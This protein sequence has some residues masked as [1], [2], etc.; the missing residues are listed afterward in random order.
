MCLVLEMMSTLAVFSLIVGIFGV[1]GVHPN[2]RMK[3]NHAAFSRRCEVCNLEF[4]VEA[5]YEEHMQSKRHAANLK[6]WKEPSDVYIE[7]KSTCPGWAEGTS[8]QDVARLWDR[9]NELSSPELALKFRHTTLSPS[10]KVS[11][12]SPY[13]KARLWRYLRSAIGPGLSTHFKE[14]AQILYYVDTH[15]KATSSLRVKEIFES[16]EAF[17]L[18]ENFIVATQRTRRSIGQPP[19]NRI[20]EVAA[21]HGLVGMLLAYRF[22][23]IHVSLY[24][25][26]KRDSYDLYLEAF[27]RG[28]GHKSRPENACVLPNLDFH[29][30]DMLQAREEI[31]GNT[32]VFSVHGCNE[33]NED[34]ILLARDAEAPWAV[35]P[36]CI[37]QGMYVGS[38]AAINLREDERDLRHSIM[39]GALSHAYEAQLIQEIDRRITNRSIFIGGGVTFSQAKASV[40]EKSSDYEPGEL[41]RA[42]SKGGIPRLLM[43]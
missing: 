20:V 37:R 9:E 5:G 22:S 35:I 40:P 31:T 1:H 3:K 6:Y 15:P 39:C 33:V 43:S 21:G 13:Q 4:R 19:V 34:T 8:V 27:E 38:T 2:T 11:D 28:G 16:I 42:A 36:C 25:L 30:A 17:N 12:L 26:F 14:I 41:R 29:E 10:P 32:M 24:D 18:I 7:F 23:N